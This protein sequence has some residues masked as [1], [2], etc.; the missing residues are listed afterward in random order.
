MRAASLLLLLLPM[1]MAAD[2][3][4]PSAPAELRASALTCDS[5]TLSWSAATDDVGVDAYDIY[6]DGQLVRSVPGVTTSATLPVVGGVTWGWYVNARDAA[7]NVSQAGPTVPVTPPYCEADDEAPTVPEGLTGVATGTTVVLSWTAASDNVAVTAYVVHRDGAAIGT[8]AGS[9]ASPP[10]TSYTDSGLLPD[11]VHRYAVT[12]RDAQGN[13]SASSAVVAVSTGSSC[14]SP[15]YGATPVTTERDLP[16]GLVQTPDGTVLYGRRDVFDIIAMNPDGSGKRS[17]G[18]VPG[19]E[20]TD[21]EGGLLGLAI[22]PDFATDRWLYAYHTSATDNRIVRIRYEETLR[23]ETL[24]VLL[25]GIPRNKYH[26]GGRL[27]FGPDGM[28]YA[29]TGDGQDPDQAQDLAGLGGKVL[30]LRPDG[31][32]PADNPFAGSYVWSYGHRNP[33]GLAFDSQGRLWQQ[34]FGNNVMDETNLVVKGGNY[35]WPACEGTNG[36]C[37]GPDLIAPVRTYPVAAASCSGIA[38]VRDVLFLAC[39]RGARVYRAVISGDTLTDV[40]QYFAGTYGRLRTV[41][42]SIDG[43]LWL[44]TSTRGDKDSVPGNSNERILKVTLG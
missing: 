32:V 24:E 15:V 23:A 29:A 38:I 43:N 5:V 10:A 42:P 2:T 17:I 3:T 35:G 25:T 28:V 22:G 4:P 6:H 9:A 14:T 36:D 37:D 11:T 30:R 41:E 16:W 40:Q 20:G 7:G 39:L 26:N 1:L 44:T 8:V 19:V 33:Q 18:T 12:A 27:R 21:G 13:V 31:G 34:E